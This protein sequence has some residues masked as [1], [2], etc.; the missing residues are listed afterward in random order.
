M[1]KD[2]KLHAA[3]GYDPYSDEQRSIRLE[4]QKQQMI[5]ESKLKQSPSVLSNTIDNVKNKGVLGSMYEGAKDTAN[6][7]IDQTKN[8][9]NAYLQG[10]KEISGTV[11]KVLLGKD[12]SP[13]KTQDYVSRNIIEPLLGSASQQPNAVNATTS[14]VVSQPKTTAPGGVAKQT[15]SQDSPSWIDQAFPGQSDKAAPSTSVSEDPTQ[16]KTQP[17]FIQ[18][19]NGIPYNVAKQADGTNTVNFTNPDGTGTGTLSGLSGKQ[20]GRFRDGKGA[21]YSGPGLPDVKPA[22]IG[23][24]QMQQPYLGEN[25]S[26]V[27]E[28][29]AYL[30]Q[31]RD[32]AVNGGPDRGMSLTEMIAAKHRQRAAQGVLSN[33]TQDN[34]NKRQNSLENAKL[35]VDTLLA[36]QRMD[37]ARTQQEYEAAQQD[38]MNSLEVGKIGYQMKRDEKG[39]QAASDRAAQENAIATRKLGIEESQLNQPKPITTNTYGPDGLVNGQNVGV[40]QYDKDGNPV[41]KPLSNNPNQSTPKIKYDS[42]GNRWIQDENGKAV[43]YYG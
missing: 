16:Y 10:G 15:P 20:A 17:G 32:I 24:Q 26:G 4:N 40:V 7:V 31:M 27:D 12:Y 25:N 36:K 43:P 11:G 39:D 18:T 33:I 21:M 1:V 29:N 22:Q 6:L 41:Y 35:G 13:D 2:G 34:Q 5:G 3:G 19:D 42:K 28:S 23:A 9:A 30:D 8:F 38:F 14:P 37:Q